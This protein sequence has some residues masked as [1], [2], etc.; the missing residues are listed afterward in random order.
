MMKHYAKPLMLGVMWTALWATACAPP[1]HF[2][3]DVA[4]DMRNFTPPEHEG[5][6]YFT[7]VCEAIRKLGRGAF[8]VIPGDLDPPARTRETLDRVLGE[9]YVMYPVVGNHELDPPEHMEYLRAL[10]AGGDTLPRI[11]RVGPPGA[12]ETCYAFDHQH[13]HFVV[14][15]V[16]YDGQSDAVD[17][18]DI[19]DTLY[20][21]LADDLARNRQPLIFV[22]GHEPHVAVPDMDSGQVRHRGDSLDEHPGHNQRFWTLLRKHGAVAYFC[23]HTHSSSVSRING[24]WQIDC[25]HARGLGDKGAPSTFMRIHV[26]GDAVRC[27]V[28]RADESATR[29]RLVYEEQLR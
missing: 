9:D 23:G 10:N 3:F 11:V 25:G 24:V 21:W 6:Q 28:Y 22:F 26:A 17:G 2:V 1:G 18:G 12:T 20:A 15:N 7:G 16:Y 13:A 4:A 5:A 19:C 14:L 27:R 29:Y 8:M